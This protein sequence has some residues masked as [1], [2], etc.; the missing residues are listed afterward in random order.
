MG[1]FTLLSSSRLRGDPDANIIVSIWA[2][3]P[4][5]GSRT[6]WLTNKSLP[7][8]VNYASRHED[9]MFGA[10]GQLA[11][12]DRAMASGAIG[13]QFE[14]AIAQYVIRYLVLK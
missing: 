6:L 3:E 11:Q 13:R 12:L 14:S 1:N 5:S 7:S 8:I 2:A 4:V 9:R 10:F